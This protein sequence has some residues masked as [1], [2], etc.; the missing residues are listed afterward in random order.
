M[1]EV[2]KGQ[3]EIVFPLLT[4]NIKGIQTAWGGAIIKPIYCSHKASV[5]TSKLASNMYSI[6][7]ENT[8]NGGRTIVAGDSQSL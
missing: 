1:R 8:N 5:F 4:N 3:R 2:I 7:S 6:C